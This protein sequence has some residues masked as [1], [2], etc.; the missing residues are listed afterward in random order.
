MAQYRAKVAYGLSDA[1]ITEAPYPV[2]ALRSPTPGDV[3][4]V[5]GTL[6]INKV[7]SSAYILVS[8]V[9]NQANWLL[10]EGSGSAGVFTTLTSSGNTTLA[11]SGVTVNTFG[12]INGATSVAIRAGTGGL[13]LD[14]A[15]ATNISIGASLVAGAI[16]IGGS[17]L[18]TGGISIGIGTGAQVITIGGS[19]ANTIH[20]GDGQAGGSVSIGE[21]MVAGSINIGGAAQTG[22]I[23]IGAGTATQTISIGNAG[24]S[25]KV[26][27]IGT[28]ATNNAVTVGTTNSSASTVVQAGT[29]G[30]YLNAPFTELPGPIYLYTGAGTPSNALALHAGDL[31]IN[32]TPTG[33]TDRMFIA[34]AASTWTNV[35]CAA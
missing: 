18:Q 22:A 4:Y 15:A 20:L 2:Q 25:P 12:T 3:G 10:L 30:I 29:G 31:Y 17:G 24:G 28:G 14:G 16:S 35:S 21:D 13:T 19:G 34:T 32:T 33:A 27:L 9:A 8:I 5:L 11:T 7:A 6:W 23:F 26:I 1:L